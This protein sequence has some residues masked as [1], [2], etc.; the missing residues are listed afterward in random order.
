MPRSGYDQTGIDRR[1]PE[2]HAA[3]QPLRALASSENR[4]VKREAPS[5]AEEP[6]TNGPTASTPEEDQQITS[7][8]TVASDKETR[9]VEFEPPAI[10]TEEPC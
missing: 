1:A 6:S 10:K 9:A 7:H 8:S 3:D 5:R 4:N 2:G